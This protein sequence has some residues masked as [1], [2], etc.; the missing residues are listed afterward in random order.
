MRYNEI[1]NIKEGDVEYRNSIRSKKLLQQALIDLVA[2]GRELSSISVTERVNK[3]DVNRG[4]FYN[5]YSNVYDI[6]NEI[7]DEMLTKMF[8]L[9]NTRAD[10]NNTIEGLFDV[11]TEY[12]KENE[13]TFRQL[14]PIIPKSLYDKIK[15]Q[16]LKL[17]SAQTNSKTKQTT[18]ALEFLTNSIAGTYIDYFEGRM[19][20]TLDQLKLYSV[21]TTKLFLRFD[22]TYNKEKPITK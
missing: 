20:I 11:L 12:L 14:A 4:T 6:V 10:T 7:K 17:L 15:A 2:S 16:A 8:G 5:H 1:T 19:D 3:A 18:I 13:Q 22:E 9:I 21:T